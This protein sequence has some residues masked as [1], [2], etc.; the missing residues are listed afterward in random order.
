M[1]RKF[2]TR[3][4][5]ALGHLAEELA[6][7]YLS[8]QKGYRL[9]TQNLRLGHLELDLVLLDQRTLVFAEVK[10]ST[11]PSYRPELQVNNSKLERLARAA[12][13]FLQSESYRRLKLNPWLEIRFD[14]IAVEILSSR[15]RIWHFPD[16]FFPTQSKPP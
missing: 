11:N 2:Q 4:S 5:R 3:D 15:Y 10:S 8:G 13:L 16:A 6:S 7:L 1:E 14:I 9:L 12:E